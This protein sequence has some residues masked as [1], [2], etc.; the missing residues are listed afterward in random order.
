[1][2]RAYRP[3][4]VVALA[5]TIGLVATGSARA[6]TEYA[7][8][9][10]GAVQ[11]DYAISLNPDCTS[12]GESQISLVQPPR[13]GRIEVKRGRVY[14]RFSTLNIL[15]RCD[16][17]KVPATLVVYHAAPGYQGYDTVAYEIVFPDGQVRRTRVNVSVR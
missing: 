12:K 10:G 15:S 2:K 1:M 8:A 4:R 9:S 16:T 13:A 17:R 5:A 11:I 3:K 7:V 14:P 6:A